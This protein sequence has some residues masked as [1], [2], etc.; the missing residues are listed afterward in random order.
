MSFWEQLLSAGD[1][2]L[3]KMLQ[4]SE[5]KRKLEDD[6]LRRQR[7][8]EERRYTLWLREQQDNE[9]FGRL[10]EQYGTII[11]NDVVREFLQ[12]I[13]EAVGIGERAIREGKLNEYRK[14]L[15][16]NP[17][18]L[19]QIPPEALPHLEAFRTSQQRL[20]SLSQAEFERRLR[21]R[22]EQDFISRNID[23]TRPAVQFAIHRVIQEALGRVATQTGAMVEAGQ[24]SP[25]LADPLNAWAIY[26]QPST[27][28]T[29][30]A[31]RGDAGTG[32]GAHT[33]ANAGA[34][35]AGTGAQTGAGATGAGT[36]DTRA[37]TGAGTGAHTDTGNA[38]AKKNGGD[39]KA[40]ATEKAAPPPQNGGAK[41]PPKAAPKTAP[42]RPVR[43][44]SREETQKRNQN[45]PQ[46]QPKQQ[47]PRKAQGETGYNLWRLLAT[48]GSN[49]REV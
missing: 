10:A 49:R 4:H 25:Y 41:A 33:G 45:R 36:T 39:A 31:G 23:I 34:G 14:E 29:G 38:G 22:I 44:G 8:E 1:V 26:R 20:S 12:E 30:G 18:D 46:T 42:T 5:V 28:S 7:D 32:A 43:P 48:I 2:F 21:S 40:G 35:G 3:Q 17:T 37:N 13:H 15:L 27:G 47:R 6:I 24:I 11:A 16:K 9:Y 19:S